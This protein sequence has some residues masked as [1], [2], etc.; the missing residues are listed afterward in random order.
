MT[1]ATGMEVPSSRVRS[2]FSFSFSTCRASSTGTCIKR[3]Q[4][5]P[6]CHECTSTQVH[7][8]L[9]VYVHFVCHVR[10]IYSS[11]SIMQLCFSSSPVH[12]TQSLHMQ[13]TQG[14]AHATMSCICL[15]LIGNDII[16]SVYENGY[17]CLSP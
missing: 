17:T 14:Q 1:C 16:R 8:P 12:C 3:L 10:P 11:I 6:V 13:Y 15:V 5:M 4:E 9:H 2:S 7:I